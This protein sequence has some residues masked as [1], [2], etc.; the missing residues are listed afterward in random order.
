M[1][2]RNQLMLV[3]GLLLSF[4][5]IS[6]AAAGQKKDSTKQQVWEYRFTQ[7]S[8]ADQINQLGAEGW[9]MTGFAVSDS[10]GQI[11]W[12]KRPK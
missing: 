12:F 4:T 9:E 7:N 5:F 3:F 2:K 10:V 11:Y 1:T 6:W 8:S